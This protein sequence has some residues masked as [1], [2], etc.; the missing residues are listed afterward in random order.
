MVG[1]VRTFLVVVEGEGGGSW[2]MI[3][4]CEGTDGQ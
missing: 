3:D 4:G 2:V 1:W